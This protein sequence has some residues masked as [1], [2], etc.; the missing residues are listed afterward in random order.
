MEAQRS[1]VACSRWYSYKEVE[2]VPRANFAPAVM[3]S[4]MRDTFFGD[5][6]GFFFHNQDCFLSR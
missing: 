1:E 3:T 2:R 4:R 6:M 5:C